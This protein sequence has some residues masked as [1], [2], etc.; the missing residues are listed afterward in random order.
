METIIQCSRCRF[1]TFHFFNTDRDCGGF[2]EMAIASNVTT[3]PTDILTQRFTKCGC[4]FMVRQP[5]V[6]LSVCVR[7]C[8][9]VSLISS[10]G[11]SM[12]VPVS[13]TEVVSLT[14]TM[15]F[16]TGMAIH[17]TQR[18]R[19]DHGRSERGVEHRAP[20]PSRSVRIEPLDFLPPRP[21]GQPLYRQR[22]Q[23]CSSTQTL[24]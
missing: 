14:S 12:A 6:R 3:K 8:V 24:Q 19:R 23:I 10:L 18:Q 15:P 17:P 22:L 2:E 4:E 5:R 1:G 7:V 16:T 9:C 11:P 20:G 21:R 13:T